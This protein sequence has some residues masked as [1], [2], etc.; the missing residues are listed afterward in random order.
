MLSGNLN[1]VTIQEAGI[2]HS[3]LS[4]GINLYMTLVFNLDSQ[5]NAYPSQTFIAMCCVCYN[6]C[7][8]C[9]KKTI[10]LVDLCV[11][12]RIGNICIDRSFTFKAAQDFIDIGT[13]AFRASVALSHS[14]KRYTCSTCEELTIYVINITPTRIATRDIMS[15]PAFSWLCHYFCPALL[16]AIYTAARH[17]LEELEDRLRNG[18]DLLRWDPQPEDYEAHL[19]DGFSSSAI[20][21]SIHHTMFNRIITVDRDE[22]EAMLADGGQMGG[23]LLSQEKRERQQLGELI[24]LRRYL[25]DKLDARQIREYKVVC[26]PENSPIEHVRIASIVAATGGTTCL[27][28]RLREVATRVSQWESY[29]DI[30]LRGE[31][32]RLSEPQPCARLLWVDRGYGRKH[33]SRIPEIAKLT[34]RQRLEQIRGV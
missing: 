32:K 17:S 30:A 11:K 1:K 5:R 31:K 4:S 14:I 2:T 6:Q 7:R 3:L 16:D 34:R 28:T 19:V 33:P 8:F 29:F 18:T 22:H 13:G 27:G 10:S 21:D 12:G 24:V 26:D 9:E 15:R 25:R 23:A 20:V